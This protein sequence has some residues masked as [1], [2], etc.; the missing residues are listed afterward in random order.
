[1][2]PDEVF[3][4]YEYTLCDVRTAFSDGATIC[5]KY[6]NLEVDVEPLIPPFSYNNLCSSVLLT[7]FIP[8]YILMH[9]F[10]VMLPIFLVCLFSSCQY[11]TLPK[12]LYPVLNGVF[13]P[14]HWSRKPHSSVSAGIV[15]ELAV[16]HHLLKANRI[17]SSDILNHLLVFCTFGMC[18]P[19]LALIMVASVSLKHHMW[20]MLIGRF[21]HSRVAGSAGADADVSKSNESIGDDHALMA[22]SAA[23]VPILDIVSGC[24]WPVV[25]SS[26]LFFSFLCWDV[27]GD[28]I[29]WREAL[30][31]PA[32]ILGLCAC[33]Y[34]FVK[35]SEAMFCSRGKI[36]A[37]NIPAHGMECNP[38]HKTTREA[39]IEMVDVAMLQQQ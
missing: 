35:F 36:N 29:G 1:V 16:P 24:V 2:P 25:F 9:S 34:I 32:L 10:Q 14:H 18:S 3:S 33:L 38:L 13:W 23:C 28:D 30:W 19:F 21:V 11:T 26:G 39:D 15:F 12:F 6:I 17:I 4:S 7:R 27:L 37:D 5:T 8:V 22:L 20:V 31:A